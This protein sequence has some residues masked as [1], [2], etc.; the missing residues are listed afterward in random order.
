MKSPCSGGEW[1]RMLPVLFLALIVVIP[2]PGAQVAS[3]RQPAFLNQP[4]AVYNDWSAYDE[5]SDN[6]ELTETLAM[7]QLNEI[8]RLRRRGVT[9]DYFM[10]DAFWYDPHGGYRTFR[11]PH[12][13]AGPDR[14][15]EACRQNRIRPGL[16][17]A[18]N[19]LSKMEPIPEWESSLNAQRTAMCL[20]SGG[21]LPHLLATMQMWYDRGV[22]MFK[23]D[24]AD[25]T[26]ATPT[27]RRPPSNRRWTCAG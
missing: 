14:W 3:F 2:I 1:K 17:L 27:A 10:M 24:F 8:L 22:R 18:S 9:I 12:W 20:F 7:K 4:V 25:F 11:Q 26:A 5:L 21:Y 19:A 23:F 13:P 6:V 15:L 16:W